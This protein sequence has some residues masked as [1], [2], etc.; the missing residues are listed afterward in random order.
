MV[1]QPLFD[2]FLKNN[3]TDFREIPATKSTTFWVDGFIR[4]LLLS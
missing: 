4:V 3:E 1:C 2:V